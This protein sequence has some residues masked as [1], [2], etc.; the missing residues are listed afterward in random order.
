MVPTIRE[1]GG[2]RV[3]NRSEGGRGFILRGRREYA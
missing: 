3:V 1:G 2:C